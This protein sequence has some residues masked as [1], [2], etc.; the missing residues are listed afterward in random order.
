MSLCT[1][2]RVRRIIRQVQ[3][4]RH[5]FQRSIL[6]EISSKETTGFQVDTHSC[7]NDR[8]VLL[9]TVVNILC[10]T[11]NKT[12]LTANLRS[13]F[14]VRETGS[15]KDWD[16]LATSFK[17]SVE[18][19]GRPC[20]EKRTNRVHRIDGTDTSRDHFLGIDP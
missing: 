9:M 8:K 11:L 10:G 15:G 18:Q 5:S 4:K 3:E 7:K 6:L 20:L 16:F 17:P 12:C 14:I 2:E 19:P 1:R 13:D